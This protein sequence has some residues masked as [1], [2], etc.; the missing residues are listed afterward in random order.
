MKLIG[1]QVI[2]LPREQ[3]WEALNNPQ[4]LQQCIPGCEQFSASGEHA[5]DIVMTAAVGPV[6]AKFKGKLTLSDIL[7]PESYTL[8]F[9][10]S[11]GAA[12]FGKGNA[13]VKLSDLPGQTE[14]EYAVQAKVGG[15]L[16]QV[17]SRLIDGVAKKM[18]DEFFTRFKKQ[19]EPEA[20][21]P[22]QPAE[23]SGQDS[24]ASSR[25][26]ASSPFT[27]QRL[28]LWVVAALIV[29]LVVGYGT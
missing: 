29:V 11:G 21:E 9:D 8:A 27:N 13:T 23:A 3:V 22:E 19:I 5:Y 28:L 25:P 16:A 24:S 15:R 20:T 14:L 4:I 18:A 17:G 6:K 12:G 26:K 7:P 1:K 2:Q 10:G